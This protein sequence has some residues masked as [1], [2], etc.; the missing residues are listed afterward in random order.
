[1]FGKLSKRCPR[2]AAPSA[3]RIPGVEEVEP[4][5][6]PAAGLAMVSAPVVPSLAVPVVSRPAL[7]VAPPVVAAPV[8]PIVAAPAKPIVPRPPAPPLAVPAARPPVTAP[9]ITATPIPPAGD[10]VDLGILSSRQVVPGSVAAGQTDVVKFRLAERS[11]LTAILSGL[12]ASSD[13][14][15][16]LRDESGTV[17]GSSDS[18]NGAGARIDRVLAA[19][20]YSCAVTALGAGTNYTLTLDP[21]LTGGGGPVSTTSSHT[22]WYVRTYWIY[23]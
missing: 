14:R 3:R 13:V 20:S 17:L 6:P 8:A 19:G 12:S 4:R 10:V 16:E 11:T 15:L 5:I 18:H 7:F 1:M 21:N 22:V 9:G 2:S 23:S